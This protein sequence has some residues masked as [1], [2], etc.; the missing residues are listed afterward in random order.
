M[1]QGAAHGDALSALHDQDELWAEAGGCVHGPHMGG[2]RCV[3]HGGTGGFRCC[4][5][6]RWLAWPRRCGPGPSTS[7]PPTG[8][9]PCTPTTSSSGTMPVRPRRRAA[10]SSTRPF[11]A[12]VACSSVPALGPD[13]ASQKNSSRWGRTF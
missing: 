6:R 4:W 12:T 8:A 3:G 9:T 2:A 5:R 10:L 11:D 7:K 1:G 13:P